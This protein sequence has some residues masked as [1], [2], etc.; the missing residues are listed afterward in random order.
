MQWTSLLQDA[1]DNVKAHR[2]QSLLSML[3]LMTG[4]AAIFC[5]FSLGRIATETANA[6]LGSLGTEYF[7]VTPWIPRGKPVLSIEDAEDLFTGLP[8]SLSGFSYTIIPLPVSFRGRPLQASVAAASTKLAE[9]LSLSWQDGRPFTLEEGRVCVIGTQ[10]AEQL[11]QPAVGQDIVIGE[12]ACHV[13]GVLNSAE[14]HPFFDAAPNKMI[15][16]PIEHL[17]RFKQPDRVAGLFFHHAIPYSEAKQL[18]TT[19]LDQKIGQQNRQWR[20]FDTFRASFVAQYN[21]LKKSLSWI[22]MITLVVGALNLLN[23]MLICLRARYH[24][25]GLRICLGATAADLCRLFLVESIVLAGVSGGLGALLG[26]IITAMIAAQMQ[27]IFIFDFNAL[28]ITL[29]TTCLI[30]AAAGIIPAAKAT[31]LSTVNLLNC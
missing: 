2:N 12:V 21:L 30:G 3:A 22:A 23:V 8:D 14:E 6:Q 24:E 13:V 20:N 10:I 1:W 28:A 15:W 19:A 17:P 25:V 9:L 16:L 29:T 4:A 31:R 27:W 7:S 11:P 5:M 26:Q 18:I